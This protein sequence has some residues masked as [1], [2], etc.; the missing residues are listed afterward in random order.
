MTEALRE[1]VRDTVNQALLLYGREEAENLRH[2]ILRNAPLARL[3]RRQVEQMKALIRA[4]ARRLRGNL[5]AALRLILLL[6]H[7]Q[8][9]Y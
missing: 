7:V 5:A 4:I 9:K 6:S 3:E 2:E 1:N 8:R